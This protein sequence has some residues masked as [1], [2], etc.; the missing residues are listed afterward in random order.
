MCKQKI[1]SYIMYKLN[2]INYAKQYG[3][4][5]AENIKTAQ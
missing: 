3:N 4:R 2:V 5:A 1:F